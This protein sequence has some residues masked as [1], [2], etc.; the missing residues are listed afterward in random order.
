MTSL[1]IHFHYANPPSEAAISALANAREVYGIHRLTFDHAAHS[2]R[3]EY[4]ATR[5]NSAAVTK[6]VR[7]A[8][9]EIDAEVPLIPA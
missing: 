3:V 8:G 4:D 9:L 2:L 1:E 7:Q 5:L 6:L